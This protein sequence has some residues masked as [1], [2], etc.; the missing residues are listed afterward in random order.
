MSVAVY[1]I[2]ITRACDFYHSL[3]KAQIMLSAPQEFGSVCSW[4]KQYKSI[5]FRRG[6]AW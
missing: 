1:Y 4:Y 5:N 2:L 3:K 6:R